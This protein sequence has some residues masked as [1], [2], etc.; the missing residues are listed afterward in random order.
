MSLIPHL[1]L[2]KTKEIK[3]VLFSILS[4][5]LN[6]STEPLFPQLTCH[7]SVIKNQEYAKYLPSQVS[8]MKFSLENKYK[9]NTSV[10]EPDPNIEWKE[11]N[12][13][14]TMENKCKCKK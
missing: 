2:S 5:S 3:Y 10:G 6:Y 14:E 7:Y 12:R 9:L 11:L 13:F 8:S 4:L 1:K